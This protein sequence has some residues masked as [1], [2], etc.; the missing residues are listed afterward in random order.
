MK[1]KLQVVYT[2]DDPVANRSKDEYCFEVDT[3]GEKLSALEATMRICLKACQ[4]ANGGDVSRETEKNILADFEY[5]DVSEQIAD[6]VLS[7]DDAAGIAIE[8]LLF[9]NNGE[10]FYQIE[11]EPEA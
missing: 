8:F 9:R 11:A 7:Q 2:P 4:T 5:S 10:W 3:N 1:Y 6:Q